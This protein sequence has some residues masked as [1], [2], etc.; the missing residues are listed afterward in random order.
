MDNEILFFIKILLFLIPLSLIL[1][2]P[3][4]FC[5]LDLLFPYI[6]GK[7][8]FF[9]ALI[10][11][12]TLLLIFYLIKNKQYIPLKNEYIF[13]SSIILFL[14]IA[15]INI[16]SLRPYLSF[17]GNAER[18]EGV[19]GLFHFLLWFWVLW[20]VF[21]IDPNF[22]KTIFYSFLITSFI[23][24]LIEIQQGLINKENRPSSTLGNATYVGFFGILMIFLSLYFLKEIKQKYIPGLIYI[25]IILNLLAIFISQSRGAILALLIGISSFILVYFLNSKIKF[26]VKIIVLIFILLF[27]ISFYQFLKT[28]YALKIP[29]IKRIAETLKNPRAYMARWIAWNIFIDAFKSRPII[30][31]GLENSPIAFFKYFNPDLFNYE[32]AIFDRPHNKYIEILVTTGIIGAIFWLIFFISIFY[33]IFKNENDNYYRSAL[34]GLF[35]VYLVQNFV[36]FDIQSSYI[37]FLFGISLLSKKREKMGKNEKVGKNLEISSSFIIKIFTVGLIL[38]LFI[39]NLFHLYIVDQTIKGLRS[40]YPKGL[41]RFYYLSSF[42]SQFLP[43]IAIMASRYLEDN[44]SKINKAKDIY[45]FL[46]IYERANKKDPYDT[47]IFNILLTHLI[48]IIESKKSRGLDYSSEYEKL[49]NLFNKFISQ[50]PNFP[51]IEIQYAQFLKGMGEKEKALEI[52][53]NVRKKYRESVRTLYYIAELYLELGENKKAADFLDDVFQR[54]FYPTNQLQYLISIKIYFLNNQKEKVE[55]L[56]KSYLARYNDTSSIEM[57]K[58]F[59]SQ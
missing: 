40:P 42:D 16:F 58:E 38:I 9:R 41:D 1:V 18:M 21:K 4:Y 30:G 6:T 10:Q 48:R 26:T 37:P 28:D 50:Y 22:K 54:G 43:E 23:I 20:I 15:I 55:N 36:L 47:R 39:L 24:S 19:W 7:A 34:F 13:Y 51:D 31:F 5:N 46:E 27:F 45:K 25:S 53:E 49:T 29:G 17:W 59:I 3:G 52:L 2:C 57:L 14:A 35:M 32:E 12:T 56:I 8:I 44:I 33:S 11:L